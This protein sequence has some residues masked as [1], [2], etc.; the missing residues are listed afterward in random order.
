MS[1]LRALTLLAL[2]P[3]ALAAGCGSDGKSSSSEPKADG[4]GGVSCSY[5]K[6]GEASKPVQLP[7]KLSDPSAAT[8]TTITTSAGAIPITF[9]V[10]QAPCTV[11]S[12]LSLAK[13]GYFDGT[14]CHRLTTSGIYVLQC[15]DPTGTG[16][17]GPGYTIADELVPDDP[18][19][20]P[21]DATGACTYSNGLVAMAKTPAPD[22]GGSQ[23]FLIYADSPLPPEYT[24]FG[25]TDAAG[26]KVLKAIGAAGTADGAPDGAP[27]TPV[28]I[29]SV[30]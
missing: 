14:T 2:V 28:K 11:H 3:L 12:F 7:A 29:T 26:L 20:Q 17:G 18:R 23:F 5:P 25:K 16:T 19:L 15:G 10:E 27:K 13:Q 22:S 6:D 30:K 21:C 9:D 24:V 8:R 4:N 1:R